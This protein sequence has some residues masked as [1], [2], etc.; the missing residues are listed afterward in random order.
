[1][2]LELVQW[3]ECATCNMP[4]NNYSEDFTVATFGTEITYKF[5]PRCNREVDEDTEKDKNYRSRCRRLVKKMNS[6]ENNNG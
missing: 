3:Q 5:C 4:L 1:M 6:K 2:R